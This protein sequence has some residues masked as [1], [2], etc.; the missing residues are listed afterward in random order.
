M[1]EKTENLDGWWHTFFDAQAEWHAENPAEAQV[2]HVPTGGWDA[3]DEHKESA[4]VPGIW[5][6]RQPGY[7]G[8][9]WYQRP[10]VLPECWNDGLVNLLIAG[11]RS[12]AQVYLDERLAAASREENGSYIVRFGRLAPQRPYSLSICVW[13]NDDSGGISGSVS[14]IIEE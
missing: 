7:C 11:V 13:H 10:F 9:V 5:H 8:V 6:E 1:Q 14:L 4:P 3:L 12:L 2:A